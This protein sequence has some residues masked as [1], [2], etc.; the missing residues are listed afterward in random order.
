MLEIVQAHVYHFLLHK[1]FWRDKIK[2]SPP[3]NEVSDVLGV[4]SL[5]LDQSWNL[6]FFG[7]CRIVGKVHAPSLYNIMEF[8][9]RLVHH[10]K[11]IP[12]TF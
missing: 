3:C 7:C 5:L 8:F 9:E 1:L 2:T 4:F 12:S 11:A 10:V 6:T